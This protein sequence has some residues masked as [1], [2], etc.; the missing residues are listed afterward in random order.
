[1]EREI[2][3][4]AE[5]HSTCSAERQKAT[6]CPSVFQSSQPFLSFRD[7]SPS[8]LKN[9]LPFCLS[10]RA[11]GS[12]VKHWHFLSFPLKYFRLI[13]FFPLKQYRHTLFP[14]ALQTLSLSLILS[15]LRQP[16][17]SDW[18][19]SNA[20]SLHVREASQNSPSHCLL[21]AAELFF[22]WC[23]TNATLTLQPQSLNLGQ[24]YCFSQSI[25]FL[26]STL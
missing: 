19:I 16:S 9:W 8:V 5:E 23:F 18:S 11:S 17:L 3:L 12:S 10:I 1:M 14:R 13:C 26:F 24:P 6:R 20:L 25:I 7:H 2:F 15:C 22:S 4:L 21:M